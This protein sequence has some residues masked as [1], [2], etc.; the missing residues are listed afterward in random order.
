MG[1][2]FS[3]RLR[4]VLLT[5]LLGI[6]FVAKVHAEFQELPRSLIPLVLSEAVPFSFSPTDFEAAD[7]SLQWKGTPIEGVQF[8][9]AKKSLEWVRVAEIFVIPRGR[10]LLEATGVDRAQLRNAGFAQNLALNQKTG[11]A[12][13]SMP[14]ALI[15][16]DRNLI[17]LT[18]VR[19]GKT[20][21]GQIEVRFKPTHSRHQRVLVD[22]T[23][24]PYAIDVQSARL[25]EDQWVFLGC[26]KVHGFGERH[27]TATLELYTLWD[28]ASQNVLIDGIATP[29]ASDSL[30]QL[31]LHSRPGK[32]RFASEES[33]FEVSYRIPERV[34]IASLGMGLGPYLY[35]YEGGVEQ[36]DTT[37]P[38]LTLYGS[39]FIN[40][41]MRMVV[42]DA[43]SFHRS[44]YS[45]L[46][47]YLMLEQVRTWDK[48]LSFRFLL[49]AH[50]IAFRYGSSTY[51][52]LNAPQG[53]ELML[54]DF[55]GRTRN[56]SLGG[57][58]Q[59]DLGHRSYYNL[60]VRW[61]SP[62]FFAEVNYISWSFE[63]YDNT[64]KNRS[65]GIS[66][67]WPLFNFL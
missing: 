17:D 12:S 9:L 28:N 35:R 33:E 6:G 7:F 29:S 40:E 55:L 15:S 51:T 11:V 56:L 32:V 3:R 46:G 47:V 42:F 31:R 24:S 67:G 14:V 23:C 52:R 54:F 20:Q 30:W 61:G 1:F 16:G 48:R 26:R 49:G 4:F 65:F 41:T 19:S 57:F 63:L 60:W 64:L 37:I 66:L 53:F 25:K 45:D 22:T 62:A 44:Y 8:R 50:G 27:P 39:Y 5:L 13:G 38:I 21:T 58:L 18:V 10:M 36:V 34:R 2:F 59:P 43:I